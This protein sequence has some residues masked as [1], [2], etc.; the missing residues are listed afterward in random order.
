M[1]EK[2]RWIPDIWRLVFN[3]AIVAPGV[4]T[5]FVASLANIAGFQMFV[6]HRFIL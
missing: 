6:Y 5:V 1:A 2:P 4:A 3:G